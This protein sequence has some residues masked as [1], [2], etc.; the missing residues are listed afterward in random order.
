MRW[1]S[2]GLVVAAAIVLSFNGYAETI[3][4]PTEE[5]ASESVLPVF[6]KV[7][8]VKNRNVVK[9][10]RFE[11]GGG[12]GFNLMD[13]FYNPLNFHGSLTYHF[14][15][16]HGF[17]AAAA[18]WMSGLSSYGEQLKNGEGLDGDFFDASRAPSPKYMLMANYQ[19]T[20]YYGKI[21][22]SKQWVM[23]LSLFGLAGIGTIAIGDD[24]VMALNM[25]LGENFYFTPNLALRIDLR[26]LVYRGPD[27][28]TKRLLPTDPVFPASDFGESNFFHSMLT[29]G[30][31]YLL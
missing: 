29:F 27:P 2:Q 14:D 28:T 15:E 10:K 7:E 24:N 23:N 31:V 6:D 22:L 20:A 26:M 11:V 19:Y 16:I 12:V 30:L 1:A 9:A 18:F 25:G 4:F 3:E 13:A 5:L 21:S 17:N 8:N